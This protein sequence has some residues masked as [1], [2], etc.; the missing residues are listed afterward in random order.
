MEFDFNEDFYAFSLTL[1]DAVL[2]DTYYVKAVYYG[3]KFNESTGL[4]EKGDKFVKSAG[5]YKVTVKI[6]AY[7]PNVQVDDI[8]YDIYFNINPSR[9]DLSGLQWD[10]SG[11][12]FTY[13]G[14]K[15]KVQITADSL[16]ALPR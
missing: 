3:F 9:Y 1:G 8:S 10:Y 12:P 2:R 7:Y 13:D 15:H 5:K 11:T 4:Y 6:S 14:A 16:A